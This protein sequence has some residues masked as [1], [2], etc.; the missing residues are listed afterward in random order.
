MDPGDF[1]FKDQNGDGEIN[2]EDR[3]PIGSFLPDVTYGVNLSLAWRNL[4]FSILFQ[5][6]A[7]N[8][9][10]NRKRGELIFTNDTNI[11]AEL[12]NNLWR[13]NGTSDRYPSAAG[14]RKG[15]NQNS[16]EY[17][18]EDG[19]FWRIQN[20]QIGYTF[21][22]QRVKPKIPAIRVYLTAERPLTVF[23][24]N[25]FNPEVPDGI[26]RQVY[27]VAAVYTA[28]LNVKF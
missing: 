19:D 16:S 26:D 5:G 8:Q 24:Y 9:I 14:L 2:D 11:D 12:F 3:V 10:L 22:N 21:N 25:G 15:W 20:V 17:Y 6:Q 4:D 13:G 1:F 7:G 27:P 28:G 18:V 23:E